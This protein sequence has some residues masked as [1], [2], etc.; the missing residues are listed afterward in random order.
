MK[1]LLFS[2]VIICITFP[3]C[4]A[5]KG[6]QIGDS[7]ISVTG[8]DASEP[9]VKYEKGKAYLI[10]FDVCKKP[11]QDAKPQTDVSKTKTGLILHCSKDENNEYIEISEIGMK[12]P[13]NGKHRDIA[14]F[15]MQAPVDGQVHHDPV[16]RH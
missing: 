2:L 16:R 3:L 5:E 6:G 1:K 9:P 7:L 4:A 11:K 15:G 13:K 10:E 8:R 14:E 12:I